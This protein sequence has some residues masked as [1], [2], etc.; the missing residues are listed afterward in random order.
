MAEV[1][2]YLRL[3]ERW[4]TTSLSS[5]QKSLLHE[6]EDIQFRLEAEPPGP[7]KN[8]IIDDL[9]KVRREINLIE[10]ALDGRFSFLIVDEN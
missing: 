5:E 9:Y 8:E 10:Q 1:V 4:H 3:G 2:V 7:V 6:L